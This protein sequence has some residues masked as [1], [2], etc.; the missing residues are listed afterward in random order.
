MVFFSPCRYTD[1]PKGCSRA[2]NLSLCSIGGK[3]PGRSGGGGAAQTRK[4]WGRATDLA[5]LFSSYL[6]PV[7][8]PGKPEGK[9]T[10]NR[11]NMPFWEPLWSDHGWGAL[12]AVQSIAHRTRLSHQPWSSH[13]R[14]PH[15]LPHTSIPLMPPVFYRVAQ[16]HYGC[17]TEQTSCKQRGYPGL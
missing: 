13:L 5:A 9:V 1:F 7:N 17:D 3:G 8:S 16:S 14:P 10:P 15:S 6:R 11:V 4:E 2:Q 12:E